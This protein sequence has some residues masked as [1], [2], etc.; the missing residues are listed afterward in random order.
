[1]LKA[2]VQEVY[3]IARKVAREEIALALK[4]LETK[5]EVVPEKKEVK[6]NA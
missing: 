5:K 6:K 1:M 4:A 2:E 3:E